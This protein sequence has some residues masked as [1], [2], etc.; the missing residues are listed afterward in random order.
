MADSLD[1]MQRQAYDLTRL[2]RTVTESDR[3]PGGVCAQESMRCSDCRMPAPIAFRFG[4][5]MADCRVCGYAWAVR[6]DPEYCWQ[7]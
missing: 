5:P 7:R 2:T 3:H 1:R 4:G 6:H